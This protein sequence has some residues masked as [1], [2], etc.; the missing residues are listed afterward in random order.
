MSRVMERGAL[1]GNKEQEQR[2][3]H[4]VR[5]VVPLILGRF[6]LIEST[7]S[8]SIAQQQLL[9]ITTCLRDR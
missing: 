5:V 6:T 3:K 2:K 4:Y 1:G 8:C 7:K 9:K